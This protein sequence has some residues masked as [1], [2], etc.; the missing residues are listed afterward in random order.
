MET[1]RHD[2]NRPQEGNSEAEFLVPDDQ[3]EQRE[4]SRPEEPGQT[5]SGPEP[6][7]PAEGR[8]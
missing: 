5:G 8:P 2:P 1:E 7:P 3:E 4:E 6:G